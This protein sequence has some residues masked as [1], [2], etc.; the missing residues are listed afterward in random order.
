MG[1]SQSVFFDPQRRSSSGTPVPAIQAAVEARLARQDVAE[2]LV[3]EDV[4]VELAR[5]PA[6]PDA[7]KMLEFCDNLGVYTFFRQVLEIVE[8]TS[9]C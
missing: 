6:R 9:R 4:L 8:G 2:A 1:Q 7:L 5:Q 3:F